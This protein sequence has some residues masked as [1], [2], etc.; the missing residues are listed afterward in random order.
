M[1]NLL[2]PARHVGDVIVLIIEC[3]AIL[4]RTRIIKKN[5]IQNTERKKCYSF[6]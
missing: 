4:E 1:I 5:K 3:C 2:R 6:S